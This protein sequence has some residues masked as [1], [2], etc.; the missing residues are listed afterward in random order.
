MR[1]SSSVSLSSL[2][3]NCRCGEIVYNPLPGARD[4]CGACKSV[5]AA[6]EGRKSFLFSV[7]KQLESNVTD[8]LGAVEV[9]GQFENANE[10]RK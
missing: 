4:A 10:R 3:L 6:C 2:V 7:P 1:I 9:R 8:F 5:W